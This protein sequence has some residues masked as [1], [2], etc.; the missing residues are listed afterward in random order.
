MDDKGN[1]ITAEAPERARQQFRLL[2]ASN[3]NYFGSFPGLGFEAV[4]PK[5]GDTRPTR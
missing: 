1:E 3:P 4:D 2:L 5:D